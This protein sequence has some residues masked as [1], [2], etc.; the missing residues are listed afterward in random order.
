MPAWALLPDKQPIL[1]CPCGFRELFD[2]SS[3]IMDGAVRD[4]QDARMLRKVFPESDD[5]SYFH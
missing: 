1:H 5:F 4:D 3:Q 2:D